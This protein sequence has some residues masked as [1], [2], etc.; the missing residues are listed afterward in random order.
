MKR[1][2]T[3][4]YERPDPWTVEIDIPDDIEEGSDEEWEFVLDNAPIRHA[5]PTEWWEA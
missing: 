3:I 4:W 1:R 5:I 2:V